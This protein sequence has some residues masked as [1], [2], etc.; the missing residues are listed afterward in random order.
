MR[1][2]LTQSLERI[3]TLEHTVGVFSQGCF[4]A[5]SLSTKFIHC[6]PGKGNRAMIQAKL[7]KYGG[8]P[9]AAIPAVSL[10]C[11]QVQ[12]VHPWLNYSARMAVPCPLPQVILQI[13]ASHEAEQSEH[14][15]WSSVPTR[16]EQGRLGLPCR[17]STGLSPRSSP[18]LLTFLPR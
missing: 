8:F 14:P 7:W 5:Y 10:F 15:G 3:L 17:R 4:A 6:I 2:P 18:G 12:S 13:G 9:F 1:S 11:S 16:A